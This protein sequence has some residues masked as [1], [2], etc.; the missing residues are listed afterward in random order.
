MSVLFARSR[1]LFALSFALMGAACSQPFSDASEAGEGTQ[2]AAMVTTGL[3]WVESGHSA[4]EPRHSEVSARFLRSRGFPGDS[5]IRLAGAALE[6]PAPGACMQL[7][8]GTAS[9]C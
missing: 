2:A 6:A 4:G 5:A 8:R 3:L 9:R 1:L 7:G